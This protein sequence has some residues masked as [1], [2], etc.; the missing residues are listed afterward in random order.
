MR[1]LGIDPG[2]ATIGF[3]LVEADR[4]SARMVTY[5]TV[6]TPASLPLSRRLYQISGDMEALISK[7]K[8]EV[9]AVEELFFNNN[10]TTG[11]AVAH[12][13]G[14]ILLSAESCGVPL[15]EYTPS[16]VKMAVVG[17]GKA[18][19][20]QVMDMTRRL[21]N[22]KSVPRP[23]DAADALALALCHA[24]SFTS[25]LPRMCGVKETI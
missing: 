22:L 7:L 25:R 4:G 15:F 14:V 12:G 21:L 5:G 1:I 16:Q 11:I 10:I 24:R 23:D 6:T 18:E 8:P 3:G 20:R 17:Y 9:I 13:R 2:V 19:K